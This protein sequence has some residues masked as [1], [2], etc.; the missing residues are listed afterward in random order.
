MEEQ[1]EDERQLIMK[2][3]GAKEMKHL[4]EE[5]EEPQP[6]KKDPKGGKKQQKKKGIEKYINFNSVDDENLID[7][8]KVLF[9]KDK[10]EKSQKPDA[11]KKKEE[12]SSEE[13]PPQE[14]KEEPEL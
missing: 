4:R 9:L 2:M 6:E 11:K 5:E 14:I 10:P 8:D 7:T 3:L 12:S 1:D 13:E